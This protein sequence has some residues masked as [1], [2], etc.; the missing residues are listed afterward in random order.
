MNWKSISKNCLASDEGYMVSRYALEHGFAYVARIPAGKI[1][2][3][4]ADAAKAKS[5]CETH[6]KGEAA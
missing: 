2:H 3:A 1:L 4:G 5:A 6:L